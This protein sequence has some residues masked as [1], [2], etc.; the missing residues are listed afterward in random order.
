MPLENVIRNL[1]HLSIGWMPGD[2]NLLS[3]EASLAI[4]TRVLRF[5]VSGQRRRT[6]VRLVL[7]T[8]QTGTHQPD[9]LVRP[10]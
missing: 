2:R 8:G 6:L 9:P 5:K 4:P 7:H 3:L 10:V 1:C